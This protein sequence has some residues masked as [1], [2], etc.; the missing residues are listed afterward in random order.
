MY[1]QLMFYLCNVASTHTA[2]LQETQSYCSEEGESFVSSF[3]QI[4]FADEVLF[5]FL[6]YANPID[7]DEMNLA[8]LAGNPKFM[9]ALLQTAEAQLRD[10]QESNEGYAARTVEDTNA[11]NS[12]ESIL[13]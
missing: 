9:K 6:K 11:G 1:V 8:S 4:F 3:V 10:T 7:M 2:H 5:S 12:L 13:H